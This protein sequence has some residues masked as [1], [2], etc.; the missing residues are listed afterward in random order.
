[1]MMLM[2]FAN[3]FLPGREY[4]VAAQRARH[5]T[6]RRATNV[7]EHVVIGIALCL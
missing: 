7:L 5:V 4:R 6:P 1:M 2:I 3:H